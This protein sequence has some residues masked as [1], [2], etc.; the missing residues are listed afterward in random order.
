M[1]RDDRSGFLAPMSDVSVELCALISAQIT[2]AR[3]GD[4]AQVERLCA[5]VDDM[6]A[7]MKEGSGDGSVA[8]PQRMRLKQLYEELVLTLRAEQADMEARL[9]QLRKVKRAVG[10]YGRKVRP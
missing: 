10:T 2:C 9:K 3:D 7:R 1:T 5:R 8:G 4:L 6:V